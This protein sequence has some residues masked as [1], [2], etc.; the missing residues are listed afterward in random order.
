MSIET[1]FEVYTSNGYDL[2]RNDVSPINVMTEI[3]D[4]MGYMIPYN[5]FLEKLQKEYDHVSELKREYWTFLDQRN[6]PDFVNKTDEE[7]AEFEN[8]AAGMMNGIRAM[9]NDCENALASYNHYMQS[10]I[11]EAIAHAYRPFFI[12]DPKGLVRDIVSNYHII[13]GYLIDSYTRRGIM[14]PG[15]SMNYF[16]FLTAIDNMAESM[17][18]ASGYRCRSYMVSEGD[19]ISSN[20]AEIDSFD[21]HITIRKVNDEY[22][23]DVDGEDAPV[24]TFERLPKWNN[25]RVNDVLT[26][27]TEVNGESFEYYIFIMDDSKED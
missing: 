4:V 2:T 25:I 13:E 1:N 20:G 15:M 17:A 21:M 3:D 14:L 5:E 24:A 16:F 6:S 9:S 8:A 18:I 11:V 7:K 27:A 19:T 10:A 12:V 26:F 23:I 22:K